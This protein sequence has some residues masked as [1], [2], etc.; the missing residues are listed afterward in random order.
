MYSAAAKVSLEIETFNV[1]HLDG[2]AKSG[3]SLG[4]IKHRVVMCISGLDIPVH[5]T[6]AYSHLAEAE[7]ALESIKSDLEAK[8]YAFKD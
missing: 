6:C 3:V 2:R 5:L 1:R 7:A 4:A 8:G